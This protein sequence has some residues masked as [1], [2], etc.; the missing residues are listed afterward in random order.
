MIWL[1]NHDPARF[2]RVETVCSTVCDDAGGVK[3][4]TAVIQVAQ[5]TCVFQPDR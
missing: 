5:T 1:S 3:T 4:S 2:I